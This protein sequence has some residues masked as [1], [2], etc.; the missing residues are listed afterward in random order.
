MSAG[1]VDPAH[2]IVAELRVGQPRR[3]APHLLKEDVGMLLLVP[4]EDAVQDPHLGAV[5]GEAVAIG[6]VDPLFD[7]DAVPVEAQPTGVPVDLLPGPLV[8]GRWIG[9]QPL[10]AWL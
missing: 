3:V 8:L 5:E 7:L 2:R 10:P 1:A 6:F 9:A 4:I